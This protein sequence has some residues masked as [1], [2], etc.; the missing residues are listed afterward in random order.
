[1]AQQR[2]GAPYKSGLDYVPQRVDPLADDALYDV[3]DEYGPLG[4]MVYDL[5]VKDVL[6]EGYYLQLSAEKLARKIVGQIGSK[7]VRN[8]KVVEQV[9]CY[10]ADL[11]LIDAGLLSRSIVTSVT[12]QSIYWETA[13][14][15]MRRRPY[16]D[17]RYWLLETGLPAPSEKEGQEPLLN[18]PKTGISSEENR[19]NAEENRINAELFQTES[20]EKKSKDIYIQPPAAGWLHDEETDRVFADYIRMRQQSGGLSEIQISAL[21]STLI[22]I[23]TDPEEQRMIIQRAT[24][25]GWKNFYPLPIK[26]RMKGKVGGTERKRGSFFSFEQR[27][28]DYAAQEAAV[29]N[30]GYTTGSRTAQE[31]ALLNMDDLGDYAGD[32]LRE[33]TG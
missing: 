33:G 1:M 5:I 9:I 12:I 13:V 20:K 27:K 21:V 2:R 22:G 3:V 11:G 19:I 29:L 7:W 18:A 4:Y 31:S 32:G 14:K 26:Q 23:S 28:Y 17:S 10:L 24:I 6:S 30:M 15:R 16:I 8:R 25:S